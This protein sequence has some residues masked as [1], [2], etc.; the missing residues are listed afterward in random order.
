MSLGTAFNALGVTIRNIL[1]PKTTEP[2]PWKQKR[3]R[4]ERFRASFAL[5]N[6]EHGDQACIGC[7]ICERICPSDIIIVTAGG[8]KESPN[9]GKSRGWADDFTLDLNACIVCELCVQVCPVDAIVMIRQQEEPAW[10][11]NGLMLTM[12]KLYKNGE[13]SQNSW[14]TGSLL[15]GMQDPKRPLPAAKEEAPQ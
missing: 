11:R 12:E 10:D 1:R 6:D 7:K 3:G 13:L 9:T 2:L 8:R 4:A 15:V 5:V 14:A